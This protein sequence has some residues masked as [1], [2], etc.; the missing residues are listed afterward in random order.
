MFTEVTNNSNLNKIKVKSYT[1]KKVEN[2]KQELEANGINV[3]VLGNGDRVVRQ[4][5]K[6]GTSIVSGDRIILM[7]NDEKYTM[8]DIT[9]WSRIC[10]LYT[11]RCV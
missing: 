9:G 4:S 5:V 7:T 3:L 2:V 10:L 11:S 8:P 1:S 6:K